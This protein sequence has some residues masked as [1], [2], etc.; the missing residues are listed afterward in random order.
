MTADPGPTALYRLYDEDGKLLYVGITCDPGARFAQ[1]KADK[2]WW[3]RVAR[4][5]IEWYDKRAN[6]AAA[7]EMAIRVKDPVFNYEHSRYRPAVK[8]PVELSEA[9]LTGLDALMRIVY[10]HPAPGAGFSREDM[11]V[12]LLDRELSARGLYGDRRCFHAGMQWPDGVTVQPG[13]D[14]ACPCGMAILPDGTVP[15]NLA[16]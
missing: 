13:D 14:G 15:P 5:D 16:A 3:P 7:E 2:H 4:K 6:A 8:V 11:L 9:Q 10:P 1:H 12:I